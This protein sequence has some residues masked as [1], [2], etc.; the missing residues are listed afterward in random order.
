MVDSPGARSSEHQDV[1]AGEEFR[2]LH[3]DYL[4]VG[5][6]AM[7]MAFVDEMVTL[8]EQEDPPRTSSNRSCNI[9][10]VDTLPEAGGHWLS[11]DY[12][13][14]LF[15][16]QQ[17]HQ[18]S[19]LYGVNSRRLEPTSEGGSWLER[20]RHR[21]TQEEVCAYYKKVR[22][23][24]EKKS[25]GKVKF[26]FE[27]WYAG[28]VVGNQVEAQHHRLPGS[29]RRTASN[30][31]LKESS[32]DKAPK[33][34]SEDGELHEVHFMG[35]GRGDSKR[36]REKSSRILI[37]VRKRLVDA[38]VYSSSLYDATASI[39]P[40][41]YKEPS[42]MPKSIPA[43]SMEA[44]IIT[45]KLKL[46]YHLDADSACFKV[47]P[48]NELPNYAVGGGRAA[49]RRSSK[50]RSSSSTAHLDAR[51]TIL[52]ETE[53]GS[54]NR[55]AMIFTRTMATQIIDETEESRVSEQEDTKLR[56]LI[57]GGGR[58]AID[59]IL[60]LVRE[61]R[62]SATKSIIWIIPRD[63]W[64]TNRGH[65]EM[66]ASVDATKLSAHKRLLLKADAQRN[67]YRRNSRKFFKIFEQSG[68]GGH[69]DQGHDE[70][71]VATDKEKDIIKDKEINESFP[72]RTSSTSTRT[73]SAATARTRGSSCT[74]T[75]AQE[76]RRFTSS[77]SP[78]I[79][80]PTTT[81]ST[82]SLPS[83]T[84]Y[85][86]SRP[87][88]RK[89]SS[90][91]FSS[92][93]AE[94]L[95]HQILDI[96]QLPNNNNILAYPPLSSEEEFRVGWQNAGHLALETEGCELRLSE[97]VLPMCHH[98]AQH[99][100]GVVSEE[101]LHICRQVKNVIRGYGRLTAIDEQER[102]FDLGGRRE[103]TCRLKFESGHNV[104]L[105]LLKVTRQVVGDKNTVVDH[106]QTQNRVVVEKLLV[107]D[108]TGGA[109]ERQRDGTDRAQEQQVL[110]VVEK[111]QEQ[112]Y[113]KIW[114]SSSRST[115]CTSLK[116]Q[117]EDPH[118]SCTDAARVARKDKDEA[119][120]AGTSSTSS[121][122]TTTASSSCPVSRKSRNMISLRKV[123]FNFYCFSPAL[124]AFVE[125]LSE[126]VLLRAFLK[127][128]TDERQGNKIFLRPWT[129]NELELEATLRD[130]ARELFVQLWGPSPGVGSPSGAGSLSGVGSPSARPAAHPARGSAP[131]P[132]GRSSHAERT[133]VS[134]SN[135]R[136][137]SRSRAQE[138]KGEEERNTSL[139]K[140][141]CSTSSTSTSSGPGLRP[142]SSTSTL[143]HDEKKALFFDTIRNLLLPA[144]LFDQP[145]RRTEQTRTG[146]TTTAGLGFQ[147]HDSQINS[148]RDNLRP[149]PEREAS[150]VVFRI[151]ANLYH[152]LEQRGGQ[153][154]SCT[155][156]QMRTRSSKNFSSLL[157]SPNGRLSKSPLGGSTST[158]PRI[159]SCGSTA[160]DRRGES[161]Q[162]I[163]CSCASRR[164]GPSIDINEFLDFVNVEE[165]VRGTTPRR[166]TSGADATENLDH[167]ARHEDA[168]VLSKQ[169]RISETSTKRIGK[170]P[171]LAP[172]AS[173][174]RPAAPIAKNVHSAPAQESVNYFHDWVS[175]KR[176]NVL[177]HLTLSASVMS[178]ITNVLAAE[179]EEQGFLS[180]LVL[181]VYSPV[182]HTLVEGAMS[183]ERIEEKLLH[184]FLK[185]YCEKIH[186][187]LRDH[188][189][190][191][192]SISRIKSSA[193]C[194]SSS[195]VGDVST[196]T[197]I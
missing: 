47:I 175:T 73:G 103:R 34:S 61:C 71:E 122:S 80:S 43:P 36:P 86:A 143:T 110:E 115:S 139:G 74:T 53:T 72:T 147:L 107:V 189:S 90:S 129:A 123:C 150:Y 181:S 15:F 164:G 25:G 77:S 158:S 35:G 166:W 171:E 14:P 159:I 116:G 99:E 194:S 97:K 44:A 30:T 183:V 96:D 106:E 136:R 178:G 133:D 27:T 113:L 8:W 7:G 173:S 63:F 161:K 50:L 13:R 153:R 130:E 119:G 75:A 104:D 187:T 3:C 195:N 92:S 196:T 89:S 56:Y 76:P 19:C 55:A 16:R 58:P 193:A 82:T 40:K 105:P 131:S 126:E 114:H 135:T 49:G 157:S 176:L 170:V 174:K 144:C 134:N 42:T 192:A 117:A 184:P 18:P 155:N 5:A 81:T 1:H 172:G 94:R 32:E 182:V 64:M 48:V 124:I 118:R 84:A 167:S 11:T 46:N 54:A 39:M 57:V 102:R 142:T 152:Y 60:Y 9:I 26:L 128:E 112:D 132:S 190:S 95:Q 69:D 151:H 177:S 140:M 109:G 146:K 149:M 62:V 197:L 87:T 17:L 79:S 137:T 165:D 12:R 37:R 22:K 179:D 121:S 59:A 93:I 6:G 154:T 100:Q 23:S 2:L 127:M 41:S 28:R 45:P 111:S 38:T 83:R 4:L 162:S 70:S 66:L 29:G 33:E 120:G 78:T 125:S 10:V 148:F 188:N 51:S 191:L 21:A 141:W 68:R 185:A 160:G 186:A 24:L 67:F 20:T 88:T 145:E 168:V 156:V 65:L 180:S 31:A 91:L 85:A 101:E 163:S 169:S 52:D 108:C 98:E 138:K